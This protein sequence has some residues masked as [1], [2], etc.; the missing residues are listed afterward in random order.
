M[1]IGEWKNDSHMG[2]GGCQLQQHIMRLMSPQVDFDGIPITSS[3]ID[4]ETKQ[5][6]INMAERLLLPHDITTIL[7][8]PPG[9]RLPDNSII[10]VV[11]KHDNFSV[12]SAYP[13]ALDILEGKYERESSNGDPTKPVW[14]KV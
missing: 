11:M 1:D 6:R 10:W 8:S 2:I 12:K 14:K 3:L 7:R 5:W 4:T 9:H 13:I